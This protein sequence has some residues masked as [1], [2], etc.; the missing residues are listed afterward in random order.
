[1]KTVLDTFVVE[2]RA[3]GGRAGATCATAKTI[4]NRFIA[5]IFQLDAICDPKRAPAGGGV[6]CQR[7]W[8]S[9]LGRKIYKKKFQ[10]FLFFPVRIVCVCVSRP[11][12]GITLLK[13]IYFD[14][15][16]IFTQIRA[17]ADVCSRF[18]SRPA[19]AST[20]C[21]WSKVWVGDCGLV[22]WGGGGWGRFLAR[23][24]LV[25]ATLTNCAAL[26]W[27]RRLNWAAIL[28]ALWPNFH[29]QLS[30]RRATM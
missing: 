2:R 12:N 19:P 15:T 26:S 8:S 20:S 3:D 21:A 6:A 22:A 18:R 10:I 30:R 7:G 11:Q 13:E 9:Y 29:L 25:C 16:N 5:F 17:A 4:T 28:A 23:Q 24:M 1:M 14:R 27:G